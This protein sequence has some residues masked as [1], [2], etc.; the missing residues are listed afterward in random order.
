MKSKI[1]ALFSFC[2]LS[3][4]GISTTAQNSWDWHISNGTIID[5]TGQPAYQADILV[6]GDSIGFLGEVNADTITVRNQVDASGKVVT[7][8][9]IDPHAHGDPL[10]R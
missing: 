8:G 5:G 2:V 6:R 9:F 7:P 10:E 3:L 1:L 4:L